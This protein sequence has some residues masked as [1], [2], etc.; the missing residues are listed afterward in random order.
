MAVSNIVLRSG[1][2]PTATIPLFVTHGLSVGAAPSPNNDTHDNWLDYH[3]RQQEKRRKKL[4]KQYEKVADN[5]V[6]QEIVRPFVA[7]S[8]REEVRPQFY[9]I[10]IDAL[11]N[12][13][14]A[15]RS[16]LNEIEAVLTK[17]RL[18]KED[19]DLLVYIASII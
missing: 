1:V 5:P 18:D 6:V 10:N 19:E 2:G 11:E 3:R 7:E 9:Q 17:R 8:V 14:V 13:T 15:L 16:L 4:K 12:D